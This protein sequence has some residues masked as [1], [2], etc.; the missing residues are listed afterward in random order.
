[1]I[2]SLLYLT[3]SRPNILFSV[4][5]CARF[6]CDP[7]ES[8]LTAAKRIL[9]YLTGIA[10]LTLCRPRDTCFELMGYSDSDFAWSRIDRRSTSGTC[11]FLGNALVSWHNK[12][13]Y[14]LA[15]QTSKVK[16]ISARSCIAQIL[17]FKHQLKDFEI[18][19]DSTSAINLIKI[20]IQHSRTEHIQVRHHFIQELVEAIF[21]TNFCSFRNS[22]CGYFH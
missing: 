21:W 12:K 19:C 15:C 13:N 20:P 8:H 18:S 5:L 6:Q 11:Q 1:M 2:G 16:Y 14:L 4:F 22:T 10:E 9:R 17:W 3:A 7:K